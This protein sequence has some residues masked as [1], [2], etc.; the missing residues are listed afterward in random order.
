MQAVIAPPSV[1]VGSIKSF[2]DL[3]EQYEVIRP[4]RMADDGDWWIEI[5]MVKT[6]EKAEYRLAHIHDDPDAH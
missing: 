4:L 2:G 5:Q 1:P 6:G 3:G